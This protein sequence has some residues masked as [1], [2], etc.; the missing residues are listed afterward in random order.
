MNYT[1]KISRYHLFSQIFDGLKGVECD[2]FEFKH[3]ELKN[4]APTRANYPNAK[5]IGMLLI[6]I[7]KEGAYC[8]RPSVSHSLLLMTQG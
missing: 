8:H 5:K 2:S 4:K 3:A 7:T 1:T 6:M